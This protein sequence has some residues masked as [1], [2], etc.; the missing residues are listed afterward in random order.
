MV[1]Y[2]ATDHRKIKKSQ[3]L[4]AMLHIDI[5]NSLFVWLISTFLHGYIMTTAPG[6]VGQKTDS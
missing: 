6:D 3:A 2:P 4:S 1:S 5:I